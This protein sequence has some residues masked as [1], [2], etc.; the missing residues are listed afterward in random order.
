MIKGEMNERRKFYSYSQLI[1]LAVTLLD[2]VGRAFN[3][4]TM[5][6]YCAPISIKAEKISIQR[7][8]KMGPSVIL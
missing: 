8:V 6:C 5:T 2:A 7:F 4:S 1:C 3:N